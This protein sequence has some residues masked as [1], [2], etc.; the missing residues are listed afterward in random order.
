MST[1]FR[2][3]ALCLVVGGLAGCSSSNPEPETMTPDTLPAVD[4]SAMP[5]VCG[6]RAAEEYNQ[7]PSNIQTMPAKMD[8]DGY[9]V[10]GQYPPKTRDAT[11]F[12]CT[13]SSDGEFRRIRKN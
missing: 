2:A 6:A 9:Y 12:Q 7:K 10:D 8:G 5:D 3:F 1:K 11:R 13:F 4:V